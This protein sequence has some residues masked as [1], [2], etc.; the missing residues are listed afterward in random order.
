MRRASSSLT[1]QAQDRPRADKKH[2]GWCNL[3]FG[4]AAGQPGNGYY[5]I[6]TVGHLTT[7]VEGCQH[8]PPPKSPKSL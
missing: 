1:A 5:S 4:G 3:I 2:D 6:D 7:H 8:L